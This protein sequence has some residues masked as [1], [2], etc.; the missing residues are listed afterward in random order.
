MTLQ[1]PLSYPSKSTPPRALL[2]TQRVLPLKHQLR[3]LHLH[4]S[5]AEALPLVPQ[6]DLWHASGSCAHCAMLH[7][8]QYRQSGAHVSTVLVR[9]F[10]CLAVECVNNCCE[11]CLGATGTSPHVTVTT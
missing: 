1:S 2:L 7:S 9:V 6:W 11:I 10:R 3:N 4:H 8:I 5:L